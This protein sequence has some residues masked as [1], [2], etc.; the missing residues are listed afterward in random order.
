VFAFAGWHL[1]GLKTGQTEPTGHG[2]LA[3]TGT[4]D[5]WIALQRQQRRKLSWF[6]QYQIWK[7][8]I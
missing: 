8:G 2:R 5:R 7:Q 3:H 4:D 6:K 1:F